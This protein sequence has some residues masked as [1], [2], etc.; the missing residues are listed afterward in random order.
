MNRYIAICLLLCLAQLPAA[1]AGSPVFDQAVQQYKAHHFSQALPGFQAEV[2]RSPSNALAHYYMAL[3]YQGMNQ[4]ALAKQEYQWVATSNNSQL[5]SLASA[6]LTQ[7]A[8]FPSSVA[9]STS[10]ATPRSTGSVQVTASAPKVVG[11][12][13]VIDWYT[14]TCAPC[15]VFA[16]DFEDIASKYGGQADFQKMN[17]EDPSNETLK[18]KYGVHGYPQIIFTDSTGAK[19]DEIQG[20]PPKAFFEAA[21][22]RWLGKK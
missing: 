3:C 2:K 11:R 12:L 16:P 20:A 22:R 4:M 14:D 5:R 6:G 17:G 7:I 8:R 1:I 15:K 13:K 19:L 18:K 9:G 10:A 21:V